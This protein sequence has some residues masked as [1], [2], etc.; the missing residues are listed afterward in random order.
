MTCSTSEIFSEYKTVIPMKAKGEGNVAS[1]LL[2]SFQKMDGT[3]EILYTDD[4]ASLSTIA[5]ENYFKEKDIT[6]DFI[7]KKVNT[8]ELKA[9]NLAFFAHML[10][11][12]LGFPWSDLEEKL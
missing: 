3:P 10:W 12:C 8:R 7:C 5:M 9:V 4:E 11:P 6:V 2:E 1:A